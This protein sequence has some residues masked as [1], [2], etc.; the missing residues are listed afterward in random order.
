MEYNENK[1]T[2]SGLAEHT[3]G[4]SILKAGAPTKSRIMGVDAARGLALL[5]MIA[6][7]VSPDFNADGTPT[8]ANVIAEGKAVALFVLLA[9]VSLAF[10]T[11]G[12][13]PVEGQARTAAAA[14]LAVR[15]LLIAFIGLVL[16]YTDTPVDV[17]LVYYGVLFLLAIPLIGLRPGVLASLAIIIALAAPVFMLVIGDAIHGLT[18]TDDPTFQSF[19]DPYRLAVVLLLTGNYPALPYMAYIC[20]GLAIGRLNLSSTQ[21]AS[22]LLGGGLALAI[23]TWVTSSVLLLHMGG[24]RQLQAVLP[25]GTNPA[26]L[27][28][29]FLLWPRAHTSS[30]W[31]LAVRAPYS[32]TPDR[33][34][35]V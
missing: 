2:T 5:G 12:R 18:L 17:I 23:S 6:V 29:D 13:H 27:T 14:S 25:T 1:A 4:T 9:G 32:D 33:K 34:S 31:L 21:V 24:L 7:H 20:A 16:G 22:R 30:W 19:L 8:I 28:G 11:G 26:Q 10:Q 15:A 35:V 3:T